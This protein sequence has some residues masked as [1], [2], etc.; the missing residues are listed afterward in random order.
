VPS[1][2]VASE[3]ESDEAHALDHMRRVLQAD[4]RPSAELR[5]GGGRVE[6]AP[7]AEEAPCS[8]T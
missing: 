4:V 1:D 5:F 8:T 6:P 3:R 7:V 2:C